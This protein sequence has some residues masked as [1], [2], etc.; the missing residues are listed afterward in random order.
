[1]AWFRRNKDTKPTELPE[2]ERYYSAERRERSS[3]AWILALVSIA[4]VALVLIG[5]FFG[6]R[7]IYRKVTDDNKATVSTVQTADKTVKKSTNGSTGTKAPSVSTPTTPNAAKPSSPVATSTTP[8]S[9]TPAVTTPA[10]TATPATSTPVATKLSNTGPASTALY[11]IVAT[12]VG[13]LGYRLKLRR[14]F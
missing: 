9:G 3:L 5:L 1:M 2:L 6:S 14:S 4:G 10:T 8:A 7:W 11:F 13:T 12:A